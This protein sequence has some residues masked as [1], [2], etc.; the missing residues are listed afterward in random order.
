MAKI[1]AKVCCPFHHPFLINATN[2]GRRYRAHCA[3]LLSFKRLTGLFAVAAP[4]IFLA[5]AAEV[6]QVV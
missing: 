4:A 6:G 3:W 2:S 1:L 5:H